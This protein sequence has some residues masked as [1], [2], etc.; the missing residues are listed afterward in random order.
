MRLYKEVLT[1]KLI[2]KCKS[3]ISDLIHEDVWKSNTLNWDDKL[4]Y[5]SS[6]SCLYT[7]I[8]DKR[9][10]DELREQT[11]NHFIK[12]YTSLT[13][14]YYIW[15]S[16]S[17]ISLHNDEKHSFGATLYLNDEWS[18]HDGGIFIWQ[19]K[20]CPNEIYK[21]ICPQ[22]N[23]MIIND[24]YEKHMVTLVSPYAIDYRYT[25]QIWGD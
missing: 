8:E 23:M 13:Y 6:G 21:A 20:D 22:Q 17:G 5:G 14:L 11:E 1:D 12:N 7:K 15:Q 24:D 10:L 18:L 2:A 9:I 25:I 3:N 19:D 4:L 16:N